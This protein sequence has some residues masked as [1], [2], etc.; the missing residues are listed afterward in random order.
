M[1]L[2]IGNEIRSA[3]KCNIFELTIHHMHGN[4]DVAQIIEQVKHSFPNTNEGAEK[5]SNA[6]KFLEL[7]VLEDEERA[8]HDDISYLLLDRNMFEKY[9]IT[10][11][12]FDEM[13]AQIV[14]YEAVYVD[15]RG[16]LFDVALEDYC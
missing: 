12:V 7:C 3:D 6:L 11:S 13:P 8:E 2:V 16:V 4:D 10:N 9:I 1:N 14:D 15:A 5:L